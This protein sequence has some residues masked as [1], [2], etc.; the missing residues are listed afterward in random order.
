MQP[1]LAADRLEVTPLK[2]QMLRTI[3]GDVIHYTFDPS[4]SGFA[5]FHTLPIDDSNTDTTSQPKAKQRSHRMNVMWHL[6]Q[7]AKLAAKGQK[8]N[9]ELSHTVFFDMLHVG[10]KHQNLN[11]SLLFFSTKT[12]SNATATTE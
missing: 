11:G 12:K 3:R 6:R 5:Y 1:R 9:I 7:N 8:C 10:N 4:I 2:I